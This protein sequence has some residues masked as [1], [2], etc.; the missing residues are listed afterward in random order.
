MNRS[1]WDRLV[2]RLFE[3]KHR[4]LPREKRRKLVLEW[5][6]VR[7]APAVTDAWT[8]LA[9]GLGAGQW[10]AAS[11][12]SLGR[13]PQAGD[14]LVFGATAPTATRLTN[15]NV[16]LVGNVGGLG[17]VP[18]IFNSITFSAAGYVVAG[19][20]IGLSGNIN[21]G[22]NLGNENLGVAVKLTPPSVASSRPSQSTPAPTSSW[23]AGSLPAR[24]PRRRP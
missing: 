12:W 17:G 22:S 4:T 6:E 8:G 5:L 10:S 23:G 3:K 18:L 2:T 7:L 21:V 15:N 16:P 24:A 11:N 13:A 9:T 1:A 14:D 19:N 20:A